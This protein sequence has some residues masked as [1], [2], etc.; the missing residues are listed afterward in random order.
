[1]DNITKYNNTLKRI[2]HEIITEYERDGDLAELDW[3]SEYLYDMA[4]TF[5]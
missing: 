2:I 1:M 4:N 5:T 3:I